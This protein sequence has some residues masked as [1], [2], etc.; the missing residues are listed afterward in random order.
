MYKINTGF[1]QNYKYGTGSFFDHTQAVPSNARK[2][3][4]DGGV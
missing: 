3:S 2:Q 4:K 1:N